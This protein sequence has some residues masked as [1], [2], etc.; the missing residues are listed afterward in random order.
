MEK[1]GHNFYQSFSL[2]GFKPSTLRLRVKCS[3]TVHLTAFGYK[4]TLTNI[5]ILNSCEF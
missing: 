2:A 3:T 5:L 4:E 1:Y